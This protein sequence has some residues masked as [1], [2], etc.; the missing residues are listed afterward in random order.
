MVKGAIVLLW[1]SLI[2][3]D[4]CFERMLV[5]VDSLVLRIVGALMNFILLWVNEGGG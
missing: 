4:F 2:S 1:R 3:G 5:V